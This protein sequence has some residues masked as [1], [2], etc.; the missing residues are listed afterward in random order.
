MDILKI[1]KEIDDN[2]VIC[3][4]DDFIEAA[5]RLEVVKGEARYFIKWKGK[6]EKQVEKSNAL[7]F[8]IMLGGEKINKD[9]YYGY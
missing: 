9:E 1:K 7:C 2:G 5:V 8:N 3:L 6:P 4:K